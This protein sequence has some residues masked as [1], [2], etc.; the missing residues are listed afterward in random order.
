MSSL[1]GLGKR[2]TTSLPRESTCPNMSKCSL[3]PRFSLESALK[4]WQSY[5]CNRNFATCERFKKLSAGQTVPDNLLPDGR[6]MG[7]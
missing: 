5:Y 3:F 4:I 6:F 1:F 2:S 7:R